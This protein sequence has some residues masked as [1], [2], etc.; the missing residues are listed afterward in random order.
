M[1]LVSHLPGAPGTTGN[2]VSG[3]PVL[4]ADGAVVAFFSFATN[5]V[6]GTDTNG[7]SD[8]FLYERATGTMTLV[9]HVPGAPGTSG[10]SL[11]GSLVLSADGAVVAFRSFATNLVAGTDANGHSD[12]FLYER[13]TGTVTLV[14]HV[15]GAPGTTGNSF[16]DLPALSADG[17]F[18]AF[19]SDATNLV[20]GTDA[21]GVFDV[22]LYER[23]TGTVTLVSHLPG[24]PGTTGNSF[25]DLPV[26]SADGAFVAFL[27]N[28]TNLVA[29][30][31][32]N[33][34][35]DV[36]LYE[37]ATG[38]VTLVSHLPG[39]PGTTGNRVSDRPVLS[40]DGAVVAFRSNATNLVA[41]TDSN[42]ASDVFL[43]ERA[44]STNTLVS[45][46]DPSLPSLSSVGDSTPPTRRG[47]SADGRW[48]VFTSLG[49][50]LVAGQVDAAD[51]VDVFLH[52]R[53]SGATTLVSHVLGAPATTGNGNS[54]N[55]VISADGAFIA[56]SSF[57]TNLVAGTDVNGGSDIFVYERATGTMT[58]VSHVSDAPG[59]TG[60][61]FSNTPDI[62]ADGA[63]VAFQSAAT[64]LVSGA[65]VNGHVDVF[66]YERA[67]GAVT[68]VSH[69]LGVPTT[70]GNGASFDAVI[71]ADGA[72]VVFES[73]A[74]NLVSGSDANGATDVFLYER[75]TGMMTLVSHVSGAGGTTG[76]GFSYDPIISP[77][78]ASVAFTSTA[79]NLVAGTDTNGTEDVFV[80]ERE[81]GTVTLISHAFGDPGTAG[82]NASFGPVISADGAFIAF[83]SSATNLV[84][85]TDVNGGNDVFVYERAT[86]TMM[87][88]SHLPG[89]PG[90]TGNSFSDTPDISAD[91]AFVAFR[92]LASN[93]VAGTDTNGGLDVFLYER[94]TGT[95]ALVSHI[96]GAEGTT[97]NSGTDS[98]SIS[99]D[100]AIVVFRGFASNL[101]SGDF[102]DASDVFLYARV[103]DTTA[104][105]TVIDSGPAGTTTSGAA[106]FIFSGTDD[107]TAPGNLTFECARGTDVFTPCASPKTYAGLKDGAHTFEVR[108]VDEA[109]NP[110]PTPA[111]R[112]WT[113]DR[114]APDTTI[115]ANPPAVTQSTTASFS[116]TSLDTS[117]TFECQLDGGGFAVCSSP[118]DYVGLG[119]S[120]H[121]FEVRAKDSVGNTD[122]T[123]ASFT[124]TIEAPPLS[125]VSPNGGEIWPIGST[126]NISWTSSGLTG[127]VKIEVSRNG[128]TSWATVV[129][130][131]AN[132]GVHPWKVTGPATGQ[133]RI[134][135]T[136]LASPAV[137]DVSDAN[138]T[139]GGGSITV[140]LPNGGEMWSIGS[141]QNITWTSTGLTG[142]VKIEVSRTGGTSWT[143]VVG[144]TANDGT[145]PWKVTGPA[146]SQA[147]IRLTSVTDPTVTDVSDANASIGGGSI[148]VVSPNGGEIWPIGSPQNISWTSSGLTGNVKIE[149]S[150]NGGASWTSVVGSTADDGV[151]A[152]TVTGPAT[153]QARIR[154]TSATDPT[155]TDVSDAN[156]S[157]GGGSITVVSPNGGEI[158]PIGSPQN[159]SWTSSGLT[160]NVKIEVSR[161]GG[162]SWTSV[163]GSTADDG[164]HAWT[165]TGP[166]TSQ[167]RIRV[168]SVTDPTV[169]DVSDANAT[170]G[171]G[172]ITVL[173]PN[174]GEIWPIGSIQ[175][176]GWTTSGLTGN[177]KIELSRNGGASWTSVVGNTADDGTHA[178]T[179]TGPV[180]SQARIRVT[181]VT[182]PTV[183]DVS[184]ANAT[185]P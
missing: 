115:T 132:D 90:T 89:A 47:I 104:P 68:L 40:A 130:S 170:I 185:I 158:W 172:S 113:I 50:D 61:S 94:A 128:G 24:A 48:V 122:A 177:V 184:D 51:T 93:L 1:T 111:T 123:P 119:V 124:W 181:S 92:S 107:I 73:A 81:T 20:A 156:A 138:A 86:S 28:A 155:V 144:S 179:V 150:R 5:L 49:P 139:I 142:N 133:A 52:D 62:S 75:A 31:D 105:E 108:A 66:V 43:Y 42:S 109:G 21:N 149:V 157:I 22:F 65:D 112:T 56:F 154:V 38:T 91:G 121:T 162:T 183:A 44:T 55:P 176:I 77:D 127:N 141:T 29:G 114:T 167:A 106:T 96:A 120:S 118:R 178:W 63:V 64:N 126:Q 145:H 18:I 88:V 117:A 54:V 14:S 134:R 17:A 69:A 67:S 15:P 97:G 46:R 136:S 32:A 45:R 87:L 12:V 34:T 13:A 148:T 98:H 146:T 58:L 166:A 131:T 10:N 143:S 71:G 37:R 159:I 160:G 9:S 110:D 164:V 23:A 6:A 174:G 35:S 39:A 27:S 95:T 83:S 26:L 7:T 19:R 169:T 161:N 125:V 3:L 85:G 11:S 137:A 101:V 153:S 102:N 80:Y 2:S 163:V 76:N 171:G 99:A 168:T 82:S 72:F 147:R 78:G 180:T 30:T 53:V 116:F 36:F 33:S 129:G 74:T 25:S 16:S 151:H 100:G 165:V 135:V 182:D 175:D 57:A 84:T 4:S 8:V 79:S 70:A 140:A 59:T 173:S 103:S 152:W 41:G 60:N